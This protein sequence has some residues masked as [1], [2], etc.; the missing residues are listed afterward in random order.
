MKTAGAGVILILI[1][2]ALADSANLIPTAIFIL[3]GCIL[4]GVTI[5]TRSEY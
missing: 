4:M 2:A 3:S 5:C 1:G